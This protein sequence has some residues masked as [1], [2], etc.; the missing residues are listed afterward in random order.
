MEAVIGRCVVLKNL[1]PESSEVDVRRFLDD[2]G[3]ATAY[4]EIDRYP[5]DDRDV[6]WVVLFDSEEDAKLCLDDKSYR[7]RYHGIETKVTT[8][9]CSECIVPDHWLQDVGDV[10]K[11][12]EDE[13]EVL[14]SS[15]LDDDPVV[16]AS[17]VRMGVQE[18][19]Q[20][21]S[22]DT[23]DLF[24]SMQKVYINPLDPAEVKPNEDIP[25]AEE[26]KDHYTTS[27]SSSSLFR[28]G[29]ES[30]LSK[31]ESPESEE[32]A[33]SSKEQ[34]MEENV[35]KS[36]DNG[37]AFIKVGE[38]KH[39][40]DMTNAEESMPSD[41]MFGSSDTQSHEKPKSLT[42]SI[43]SADLFS[44]GD[45]EKIVSKAE[46]SETNENKDEF[47]EQQF[48]E[49]NIDKSD[50]DN[51]FITV[52]ERKNEGEMIEL[53]ASVPSDETFGAANAQS[54][55][56]PK[57][58]T[59]SIR[60]ADLFSAGDDTNMETAMNV[61]ETKDVMKNAEMDTSLSECHKKGNKS[62]DDTT[63]TAQ[64]SATE[65]S[66]PAQTEHASHMLQYPF[67]V[68]YQPP[69]YHPSTHG[70]MPVYPMPTSSY[71]PGYIPPQAQG[72][73]MYVPF[74]YIPQ[75]ANAS[76]DATVPSTAEGVPEYPGHYVHPLYNVHFNPASY[77]TTDPHNL[78]TTEL[79]Q[80]KLN[81]EKARVETDKKDFYDYPP[82]PTK[83]VSSPI[84]EPKVPIPK[85]GDVKEKEYSKLTPVV[86]EYEDDEEHIYDE[87]EMASSVTK[88]TVHDLVSSPTAKKEP[89]T[90][91]I[92]RKKLRIFEETDELTP[93]PNAFIVV[94]GI[95]QNVSVEDI[96]LFFENK[97]RSGGGD[98]QKIEF[99]DG[100][101]IIEF[102]SFEVALSVLKKSKT[103]GIYFRKSK[104]DVCEYIPTPKDPLKMFVKGVSDSTTD[105]SIELFCEARLKIAPHQ[106]ERGVTPGTALLTFSSPP[107]IERARKICLER[108][109][110]GEFWDVFDVEESRAVLVSGYGEKSEE[111]L[112]Y[113]FENK[114]RS[115]GGD[116]TSVEKH[117]Q[118]DA[119]IVTFKK[120]EDAER[121]CKP[122][123]AHKLDGCD[124]EVSLYYPCIDL[125]KS[126]VI[127]LPPPYSVT[128]L[129]NYVMRF[130][131]RSKEYKSELEQRLK[132]ID[133]ELNWVS[134]ET[135]G[136]TLLIKCVIDVKDK[137]ARKKISDWQDNSTSCV[138]WFRENIIAN[139]RPI[140]CEIW[141]IANR[142]FH[143]LTVNRPEAVALFPDKQ[144]SSVVIVGEKNEVLKLEAQ[145]RNVIAKLED[146]L[147]MSNETVTK[148]IKLRHFEM[149]MMRALRIDKKPNIPDLE[150]QIDGAEREVVLKGF[151]KDVDAAFERITSI[152]KGLKKKKVEGY[153]KLSF[154]M[155][156]AKE[157]RDFIKK[158]FSRQKLIGVWDVFR[159]V[160][161]F[162]YSDTGESLDKCIS[163]LQNT[164]SENH[165]SRTTATETLYTDEG[166]TF[167][168]KL[169]REHVG[170][171]KFLLNDNEIVYSVT[172][173]DGLLGEIQRQL[174]AFL[175]SSKEVTEFVD[176]GSSGKYLYIFNYKKK[177]IE[178][179]ERQYSRLNVT[180]QAVDE[181]VSNGF[182]VRGK[183]DGCRA[184]ITKV[185][186]LIDSVTEK[187]LK[188][189]I[190]GFDTFVESTSGKSAI[191]EVEF[192]H[193]CIIRLEVD[194]KRRSTTAVVSKVL[195][196]FKEGKCTVS[197]VEGDLL[198]MTADALVCPCFKTLKYSIGLGGNII[199]CGGYKIQL[200]CDQISRTRTLS[201]GDVLNTTAGN[202]RYK[203]IL[204]TVTPIYETQSQ[205]EKQL[206][207][208]T[209]FNV[210]ETA[211]KHRY[212]SIVFPPI[213]KGT[214]KFPVQ[215]AAMIT[216][217]A[218]KKYLRENDKTLIEK[219]TICDIQPETRD[220]FLQVF[221]E[222]TAV[223]KRDPDPDRPRTE[224]RIE[225]KVGTL[226]SQTADVLVNSTNK[227]LDMR[228]GRVSRQLLAAAGQDVQDECAKNYT[229]GI[230]YGQVAVTTAGQ[231][232]TCKV[233]FHGMLPS[234][235]GGSGQSVAILHKFVSKCLEDADKI[236][237]R[238]IAFPALG[239]GPALGYPIEVVAETMF[240]AVQTYFNSAHERRIKKVYFVI[241][242]GDTD[243]IKAFNS[244]HQAHSSGFR[245]GS[246]RAS[247]HIPQHD[248]TI[249]ERG[250]GRS[251]M[252]V[253]NVALEIVQEDITR[254]TTGAIVNSTLEKLNLSLGLVSKAILEAAGAGIQLECLQA[255]NRERIVK[256]G[257]V[258]TTAGKLMCQ[259][260][261][262]VRA[263]NSANGWKD[264][265]IKCLQ[266]AEILGL[267]SIA[268][269]ALGTGGKGQGVDVMAKCF[270]ESLKQYVEKGY[271]KGCLKTMR[272][273][274]YD[275]AMVEQFTSTIQ[276]QTSKKP[277][278]SLPWRKEETVAP[279][280]LHIYT[281]S[282]HNAE[283]VRESISKLHTVD[284]LSYPASLM[285]YVRE[286]QMKDIR[287]L[288]T[289][290]D[291]KITKTRRGFRVDGFGGSAKEAIKQVEKRMT[292]LERGIL[293]E[294]AKTTIKL[295]NN[296]KMKL[297]DRPH[298]EILR[299]S[300]SDFATVALAFTTQ[301]GKPS[302]N[303]IRIERI[304]NP[305]LYM[306]YCG[307]KSELEASKSSG[308][309]ERWL[310]HG[311]RDGSVCKN[312]NEKGFD[313]NYNT[314]ASLG[315]G[316]YFAVDGGTSM[317]YCGQDEMGFRRMYYAK[318]LTGDY[319][320]SH[321]AIR[322]PPNKGDPNN[323]HKTY[324]SVVDNTANPGVFV[325]FHDA[326]AYPTFLVTFR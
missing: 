263:R 52:G 251:A 258:V 25:A 84:S 246:V 67:P 23:D 99:K 147:E 292:T 261:I 109:C 125:E 42:E 98:I 248:E 82:S 191:R 232:R 121:V 270:Y 148:V 165:M 91:P 227:Y 217:S 59:E 118:N 301:T 236:K 181:K 13:W 267:N 182:R 180:I 126:S 314:G 6:R 255:G 41:D 96:E 242:S 226:V 24:A 276:A 105:E 16:I 231:L 115:Q 280:T 196:C 104:I 93:P 157:T 309:I 297:S 205:T 132:T 149:T 176:A 223:R 38:R 64:N 18:T 290:L 234:W 222:P 266:E 218:I 130:L 89:P 87:I 324:D 145:I 160:T 123:F 103:D 211:D 296:W 174:H 197:Y 278:F 265:I 100:K 189:E 264:S 214:Y 253:G 116:V 177:E 31:A 49:E 298:V 21:A 80:T 135:E 206:L 178:N 286:A 295:P 307:K 241:W 203:A 3:H 95:D 244:E 190:P 188:I 275:T 235:D 119:Y 162:M 129:D 108:A 36:D 45:D 40:S 179:I 134:D 171:L 32:K 9:L 250:R 284:E 219:I 173:V 204:H 288:A 303:I 54:K 15:L 127:T 58:L 136:D 124:L 185:R 43:R 321:G 224:S 8:D 114:R 260:I 101:V 304:Q 51:E 79:N 22:Y 83:D 29:R 76:T 153:T 120:R 325:I 273:V 200:E 254:Q 313:R 142:A 268:F 249:Y 50:S 199:R 2:V 44:A 4:T 151:R 318:V 240:D 94:S 107:D 37:N 257:I 213:G 74:H 143:G 56:K 207:G 193:N 239:T 111:G 70:Q 30:S 117:S 66:Q 300:D 146:E 138:N 164:L 73:Y 310:W 63:N 7:W 12:T 229:E 212:T 33:G 169:E 277:L 35:D 72:A 252:T 274:L 92:P 175:D 238:S 61:H 90:L 1:P 230:S 97:K 26:E 62:L 271:T 247:K 287:G 20:F 102:K 154:D 170:L 315:Q 167:I 17:D 19:E 194:G 259:K 308:I 220:T 281:D 305:A 65:F 195:S 225:I 198:E 144:A 78:K 140:A 46:S 75:G 319:A 139:T 137:D 156:F 312:I 311:T 291:V 55:D 317:S 106:I 68:M 202:L 215:V 320:Q 60:S 150:I 81:A 293:L 279:V 113:Y 183:K 110:D 245:R 27:F 57:S 152:I 155:L 299:P 282:I 306:Q 158:Q 233:I 283:M 237:A 85:S 201:Y 316:V 122:A 112:L 166:R 208:S 228:V 53:K 5:V 48:V 28:S 133:A 326:Q 210:L 131:R 39:E 14:Q 221:A 159:K 216:V 323:P 163:I 243:T 69:V 168:A 161:L 289:K 10:T 77:N 302:Y 294:T 71:T 187:D 47:S 272:I 86:P 184:V 128:D 209:V 141:Q 172:D 186:E 88:P 34:I 256:E 192:K 285:E 269:P 322:T 262:H 11:N